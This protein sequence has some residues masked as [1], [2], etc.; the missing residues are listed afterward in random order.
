[1]LYVR[2]HFFKDGSIQN[3]S[4]FVM[5]AIEKPIKTK[6]HILHVHRD[7][8]KESICQVSKLYSKLFFILK[9]PIKSHIGLTLDPLS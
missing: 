8:Y 4:Y 3:Y 5:S 2:I 1:M 6:L 9:I 7:Q